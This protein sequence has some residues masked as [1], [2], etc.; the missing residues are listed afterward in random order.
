MGKISNR[1]KWHNGGVMDFYNLRSS[2]HSGIGDYYVKWR[3]WRFPDFEIAYY[4]GDVCCI[5][6]VERHYE[7]EDFFWGPK[8]NVPK[9]IK[10]PTDMHNG[11]DYECRTCSR[12]GGKEKIIRIDASECQIENEDIKWLH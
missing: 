2:P 9:I 5:Q 10:C 4:N 7:V 1:K 6:G 3:D 12:C 8:I 11:L